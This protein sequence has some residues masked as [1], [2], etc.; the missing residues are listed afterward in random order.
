M[1]I[2]LRLDDAAEGD[3]A[4]RKVKGLYGRIEGRGENCRDRH[5]LMRCQN[6]PP[7]GQWLG[8]EG[9]PYRS[10][11]AREVAPF[12]PATSWEKERKTEKIL[13]VL[14]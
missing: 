1:L 14:Q 9:A 5:V 4:P 7:P 3:E 2:L 12:H 13:S 6:E 8:S 10:T 11:R